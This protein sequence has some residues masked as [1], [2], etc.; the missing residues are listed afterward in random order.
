MAGLLEARIRE[1]YLAD[2]ACPLSYEPSGED[3][4]SPCL[5]EA[6]LMR[7]VLA[8]AEFAAWLARFLPGL[9]ASGGSGWLAP[10]VVTDP[11]DPKLAHLDGL[12]LSRAWMLEGIA[13]G[14][15]A[16]DP[17]AAAVLAAASAHRDAGL[18][19]VTGAHYE[20]G[21]WLGT[22]AAYLTTRRGLAAPGSGA[23]AA[24]A[25]TVTAEPAAA[26][27]AVLSEAWE[28]TLRDDPLLATRAGDARYN[29]RLP[30]VTPE[31]QQRQAAS[32]RATL[33]RLAAIDRRA[34]PR[35]DQV[36]YDILA[37]VQREALAEI[38]HK[39]WL[40]PI[41]N[42]EGFHIDVA[43]LPDEMPLR[44]VGEYE[45]YMSRLADFPRYAREQIANMRA[46]IAGGVT[47]P[48]A[49]LAGSRRR[50]PRI[51]KP[52]EQSVFCRAVRGASRPASRGR[53]RAAARGA[54]RAVIEESVVPGLP[55][56]P[57][58]S[59]ATSTCPARAARRSARRRCP[60]GARFYAQRVRILHHA[61]P[62]ARGGAPD[63]AARG[64]AD[65]RAR[66]TR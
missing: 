64:G 10:A 63:R 41:T 51:V 28:D 52:P 42:R 8:P 49:V 31:D 34:L 46:G 23:S 1:F 56:V 25:T 22:F 20:G 6:D 17:R 54:A 50:W 53:P 24:A 15:P 4:L 37:R 30:R 55:R 7:R 29:G 32:A 59:C 39:A 35:R 16:G 12:N 65:P 11:S 36:T 44:T 38:E 33:D 26:F 13:S 2:E 27:A 61:R 45:A 43:R 66:W 19:S 14:L 47:L 60:T 5:A 58:S 18:A 62:D 21:H 9:P 57:A 3:F 40:V 48:R